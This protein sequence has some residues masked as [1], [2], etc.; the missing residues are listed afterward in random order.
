MIEVKHFDFT[1]WP[2]A[3]VVLCGGTPFEQADA[4]PACPDPA[5]R[6]EPCD[7]ARIR[8]GKINRLPNRDRE[9][10]ATKSDG[11]ARH[12]LDERGFSCKGLPARG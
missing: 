3:A 5:I 4:S 12:P 11:Y 9:G 1:A 2:V 6:Q 10:A 8:L 7:G